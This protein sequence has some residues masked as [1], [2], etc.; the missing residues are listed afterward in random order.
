MNKEK[1]IESFRSF[2]HVWIDMPDGV[3]LKHHGIIKSWRLVNGISTSPE[4]IHRRI[5][6]F[7]S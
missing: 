1:E 3:R 5:C 6:L 2:E 4:N 7:S